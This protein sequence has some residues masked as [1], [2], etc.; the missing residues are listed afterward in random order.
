[1]TADEIIV[2][3]DDD[4]PFAR[5]VLR[6]AAAYARSTQTALRAIQVVD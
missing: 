2:G 1:M 5:A 3:I 6:R 4:S